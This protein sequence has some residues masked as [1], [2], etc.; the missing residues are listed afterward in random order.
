M[1][2]KIP[3]MGFTELLKDGYKVRGAAPRAPARA[4]R[5]DAALAPGPIPRGCP[6]NMQGLDEA[7]YKNIAACRALSQ[8]TKTS[9]GP[10]GAGRA[11]HVARARARALNR[12]GCRSARPGSWRWRPP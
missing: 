8:V 6:Q 7:V 1:A 10:N 2:L 9:L 11:A 5:P 12:A 4:A 3:K